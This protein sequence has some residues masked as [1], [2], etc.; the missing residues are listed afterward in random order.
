MD[1]RK[2]IAKSIAGSSGLTLI[3]GK[4]NAGEKDI[5][6]RPTD[7]G[8]PIM[9]GNR[10][11]ITPV[12]NG[13]ALVNPLMGWTLHYYDNNIRYYGD[14][15]D[16]ADTMDD[17]P[18]LSTVYLRLP[19]SFIE[20]EEGKFQ[21][22]ILDTPAQRWIEKGKR[23]ALRITSSEMIMRWAT[24]EWV[25]KAGAKGQE[26]GKDKTMDCW[27]ERWKNTESLWE[28]IYDDP[29][30]LEKAE[31]FVKA[32]AKRY[33]GNPN[34]SFID[35][36]HFGLWGEGHTVHTTQIDYDISVM[37]RHIDLYCTHFK[38]TQLCIS[39]DYA[40]YNKP[41]YRFP[42]TD[43]AFSKGVTIRDD[44]IMVGA[45]PIHW[46]HAE[47]AQLFWHD[48][49][50]ILETDHYGDGV[51]KGTWKEDL[52][53]KS[54]E[55]YHASYMSIHWWPKEFLEGNREVI[56]KINL[57][58]G[59]RLQLKS[60]S[61]PKKVKLG[62]PFEITQE[63]AN[64]GVAPCYPGGFPCVTLK[65]EKGGIVS[66]LTAGSLNVKELQVAKPQEEI[67]VKVTSTFTI[68][69]AFDDPVKKFFRVA[70]PGN[71]D[72]YVSVGEQ[73]GTPVFEL[74]YNDNDGHKRYRMGQIEVAE[75]V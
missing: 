45:Y 18:G 54:V 52:F 34:V 24:P 1:R 11:V 58:M 56:D 41:G 70:K 31:N 64:A 13:K 38:K 15:L 26:W 66:V 60:I 65:D 47:M 53:I 17:F 16:P 28:P 20:P 6:A 33:D 7:N 9:D 14:R 57:R 51:R 59:Y 12:D 25:M 44:S 29:V 69:A 27:G 32:M 2:F 74:P 68:A 63:W 43:Y 42:I 40:G 19:W 39:D 75:G 55:E 10:F 5:Y 30:F 48:Y 49:P 3:S 23:I 35:I 50:V 36:G 73:D 37:K 8:V 46:R 21:W 72:L 62:E 22:E 4:I 67:P 61:W 71:Y